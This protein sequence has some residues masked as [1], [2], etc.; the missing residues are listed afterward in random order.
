MSPIGTLIQR[1]RDVDN[2]IMADAAVMRIASPLKVTAKIAAR[3]GTNAREH[4]HQ[5]GKQ[6]LL[7]TQS[8]QGRPADHQCQDKRTAAFSHPHQETVKSSTEDSTMTEA[9]EC[10]VSSDTRAAMEMKTT[11]RLS[12]SAKVF[13]TVLWA[14][15]TSLR[16]MADALRTS[17][18]GTSMDTHKN[19]EN[20]SSVAA[21]AT[22]ITSM[23]NDRVKMLAW[24]LITLRN[25]IDLRLKDIND[26]LQL[27]QL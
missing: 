6:I 24:V 8:N 23:T 5:A 20:L 27:C 12:K 21:M 19:A 10:A 18:S 3:R 26:Q 11:S 2:F 22:K 1:L 9:M 4:K 14:L 17:L 16:F 13:A 15:V 7:D 25:H